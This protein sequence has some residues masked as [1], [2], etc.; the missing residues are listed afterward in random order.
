MNKEMGCDWRCCGNER[1]RPFSITLLSAV[2]P[3]ATFLLSSPFKFFWTR[4]HL[5]ILAQDSRIT[6][7]FC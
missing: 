1:R 3:F 6:L 2:L 5:F 4:D 7:L